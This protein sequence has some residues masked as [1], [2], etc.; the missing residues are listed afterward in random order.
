MTGLLFKL[1]SGL[2]EAYPMNGYTGLS[3][4]S[5]TITAKVTATGC[6]SQLTFNIAPPLSSPVEP[7]LDAVQPDCDTFQGIITVTN[8]VA[9]QTYA[10]KLKSDQSEPVYDSYP[11]GGYGGLDPG[12]YVVLV[13]SADGCAGSGAEI[14]L[15]EP[16]CA[17]IFPTQT[18]CDEYKCITQSDNPTDFTLSNVCITTQGPNK[19]SNA[20]P[21]VFFYYADVIG[22]AGSTKVIVDQT[23]DLTALYFLAQNVSN[24]RVYSNECGVIS[25]S[26]VVLRDNT[27]GADKGDVEISFPSSAGVNYIISVKYDVKSIVGTNKTIGGSPVAR[28]Q[29]FYDTYDGDAVGGSFGEISLNADKN[30]DPNPIQDPDSCGKFA[31]STLETSTSKIQEGLYSENV[32]A[33][34]FSAYPVPFRETL[35]IQYAFDYTSDVNIQFFDLQGR[36]LRTYEVQDA[37]Q[38]MITT[39]N[40]DFALRASQIYIVKITTDRD[41]F[42]KNIISDK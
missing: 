10:L 6:E 13:K 37:H 20:V 11:I 1:D 15:V 17:H 2:F 34:D 4:G 8:V 38:G 41:V 31:S 27:V 36:L 28:F 24:I 30:C 25:P 42:T 29:M 33:G 39:L 19:I 9:G 7:T 12:V 18:D 26:L 22:K 21:G 32:I 5:H 40:I 35:N 23:T 16:N 14:T 3:S